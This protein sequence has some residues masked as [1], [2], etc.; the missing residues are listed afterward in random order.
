MRFGILFRILH[1]F[2]IQLRSCSH[3]A[4]H[5][6]HLRQSSHGLL[7]RCQLLQGRQLLSSLSGMDQGFFQV[8]RQ[9]LENW[10]LFFLKLA[11]GQ[12][13]SLHT[14]LP[15]YTYPQRRCQPPLRTT[16]QT[17]PW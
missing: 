7:K 17:V 3:P 4:H 12:R 2:F 9:P 11:V 6:A 10:G 14:G 1:R 13:L 15:H 5:S 8:L 16:R